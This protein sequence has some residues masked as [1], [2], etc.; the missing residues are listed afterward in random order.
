M[1]EDGPSRA[2]PCAVVINGS[3]SCGHHTAG[4]QEDSCLGQK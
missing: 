3:H 1:F 4:S 2:H